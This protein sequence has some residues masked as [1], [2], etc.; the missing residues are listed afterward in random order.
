MRRARFSYFISFASGLTVFTRDPTILRDA[1]RY[2]AVIQEG[3]VAERFALNDPGT[4]RKCNL[5]RELAD[6]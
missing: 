6:A 1:R 3:A 5:G 2:V 4:P